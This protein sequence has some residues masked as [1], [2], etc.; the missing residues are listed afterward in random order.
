MSSQYL[1]EM[2]RGDDHALRL[3]IADEAGQP[4]DITG[5]SFRSSMKLSTEEPDSAAVVSVTVPPVSG[6]DAT[7]GI[8]YISLPSAQTKNLKAPAVYVFDVQREYNGKV[9]TVFAGRVKIKP[10]VT[11]GGS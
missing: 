11:H 8:A 6:P 10:D 5:W 7:Q 4:V 1:F 2:F 3:Q 9:S